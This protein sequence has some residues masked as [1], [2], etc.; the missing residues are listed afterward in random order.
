MIPTCSRPDGWVVREGLSENG[1]TPFEIGPLRPGSFFRYL[2]ACP[3]AK[4]RVLEIQNH[5][6]D[7]GRMALSLLHNQ[8]RIAGVW[9]RSPS[10][11]NLR[12]AYGLAQEAP[13]MMSSAF[14]IASTGS[15]S[16]SEGAAVCAGLRLRRHTPVYLL[17]PKTT[18]LPASF[19][20]QMADTD[21]VFQSA[22]EP[23][24]WT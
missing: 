11:E 1:D 22:G 16:T 21:A 9:L 2:Q 4:I 17:A 5:G 24:Y 8:A 19:D 6:H 15:T 20:F 3:T 12:A 13:R 10:P 18:F 23:R 7:V 14:E